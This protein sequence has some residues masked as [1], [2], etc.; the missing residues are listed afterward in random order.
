MNELFANSGPGVIIVALIVVFAKDIVMI[1]VKMKNGKSKPGMSLEYALS[2]SQKDH[3]AI[4]VSLN[5]H[6]QT[7]NENTTALTLVLSKVDRIEK[8]IDK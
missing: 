1:V 5:Q 4:I 8:G 2:Q 6:T 7:L 3:A